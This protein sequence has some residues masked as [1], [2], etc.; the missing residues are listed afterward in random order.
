MALTRIKSSDVLVTPVGTV[1]ATNVQSAVAELDSESSSGLSSKQST[2]VSGT[3]IKTLNGSS[4][5]GSGDVAIVVT[6]QPGGVYLNKLVTQTSTTFVVPAGVSKIRAY[7]GGKGGDGAIGTGV[8]Y[9]G[10]GA[11]GGFAFGDIVTTQGESISIDITT[12]IAK[13]SRGVTDLLTAN[14]GANG[15]TG[16]S[17]GNA[18]GGTASIHASVINGAA[19]TGGIGTGTIQ[20]PCGGGS[21]GSPLGNGFAG[22][23][24]G[25][26]GGIGGIGG[27]AGGG[28]GGAATGSYPGGAGGPG[29]STFP[30]II[31]PGRSIPFTDP[32]LV[33]CVSSASM[34]NGANT[35]I[36]GGP[37][38]G[39]SGGGS[40]VN[41]GNGGFGAGGG[42][43]GSA[44]GGSGG[45]MGGGGSGSGSTSRGGASLACGGGGSGGSIAGPGGPATVWIFY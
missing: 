43:G 34:A 38:A 42:C 17:G 9:I 40:N 4:L 24:L 39:G 29:S 31:G 35:A 41:G 27:A 1:A 7:A 16:I 2:L 8:T 44:S 26:G 21:A 28:A 36:A 37:G 20:A 11:G 14:P 25:G 18:A 32:L 19:Y 23:S 15:N 13:V 3:S 33:N 12:G 10:A 22:S 6:P 5:L 45:E 30:Y